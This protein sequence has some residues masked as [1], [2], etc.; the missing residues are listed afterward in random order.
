MRADTSPGPDR[1]LMRAIKVLPC[2]QA[3]AIIITLMLR[4]EYVP[5]GFKEARTIL[6]YKDGDEND[7]NNWRPISICSVFRRIVDKLMVMKLNMYTTLNVHQRGFS[8]IP[9][10]HVNA[11]I[12]NGCLKK[13]KANKEDLVV[14]FLDVVKA[15]DKIGHEH[16]IQTLNNLLILTV[17]PDLVK[18]LSTNTRINTKGNSSKI[19]N[20]MLFQGSPLLPF[21]FNISID[22]MIKQLNET[23]VENKYGFLI[24]P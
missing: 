15:F 9:G 7:P 24:S 20:F 4:H 2:Q 17:L 23:E 16:L 6:I 1:V 5:E 19:V 8:S 18:Q 3:I 22:F 14:I 21:L 12:L 13:A 10:T 11:S